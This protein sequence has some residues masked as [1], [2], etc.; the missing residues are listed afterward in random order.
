[1]STNYLPKDFLEGMSKMETSLRQ[2]E[3]MLIRL[4][5]IVSSMKQRAETVNIDAG[6]RSI[7]MPNYEVIYRCFMEKFVDEDYLQYSIS[8]LKRGD[9]RNLEEWFIVNSKF[10]SVKVRDILHVIYQLPYAWTP[11]EISTVVKRLNKLKEKVMRNQTILNKVTSRR[12][13]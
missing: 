12:G 10:S 7:F 1:M 4:K 5:D 3:E 6:S 11:Q 9:Q 2:A 8:A 13:N